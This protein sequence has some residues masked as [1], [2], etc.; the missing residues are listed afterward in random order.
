MVLSLLGLPEEAVDVAGVVVQAVIG[1]SW[2]M[3]LL[4]LSLLL[5]L[6]T[7]FPSLALLLSLL[8]VVV[9]LGTLLQLPLTRRLP[10]MLVWPLPG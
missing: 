8:P 5:L 9:L 1:M 4:L 2:L 7:F 6:L 10:S 3:S